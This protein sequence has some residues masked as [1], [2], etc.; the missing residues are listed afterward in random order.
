MLLVLTNIYV[1]K[2]SEP[3]DNI[4]NLYGQCKIQSIYQSLKKSV[5]ECHSMAISFSV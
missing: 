3:M 4:W 2:I 5:C 1:N